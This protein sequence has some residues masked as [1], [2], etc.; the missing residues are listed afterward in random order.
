MTE[1]NRHRL[2]ALA[3]VIF[4][5]FIRLYHLDERVFHHD[6][7]V[8][9]F[10]TLR[11]LNE[12]IYQYDPTYHGPFL[13]HS[14]AAVF[15][16]LGISDFT[17]RLLPALFG[18]GALLLIFLLRKEL[19]PRGALF[20]AALLA[21]SPSMVY[22]SRFFRNDMF[23]VFFTLAM[24]VGA[25]RYRDNITSWRRI[26]YLLLASASLALAMTAKENAYIIFAMFSGYL[27]L[28]LLYHTAVVQKSGLMQQVVRRF[29]DNGKRNVGKLVLD[30]ILALVVFVGIFTLLYTSF[31]NNQESMFSVVESAFS[32]WSE[33]HRI[34]R[35]GGPWYFYLPILG[36]YESTILIFGVAGAV[37]YIR[38]K[39]PFLIFIA[40]WAAA[41]LLTYSY[42]QEKVPWLVVHIVLPFGILA[43]TYISEILPTLKFKPK[44]V[45]ALVV[46]IL[47]LSVSF[48]AYQSMSVNFYKSTDP[49]ELLVYTQASPDIFEVMDKI[50]ELDG[51]RN[52]VEI[53][54]ADPENLYWPLPWYLR[55]YKHRS[56]S[57]TVPL[58]SSAD[59]VIVPKSRS[60]D[61]AY[62][63]G[64]RY[65]SMQFDLRP[66]REFIMLYKP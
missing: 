9:G 43:G 32:H 42:L 66:G 60:E 17:A 13:F 22:Y 25:V 33:M 10:F 40:Y 37:H 27:G 47:V 15:S 46:G 7:S 51:G 49:D 36:M 38:E 35:I 54:V 52:R 31:F 5:L 48:S 19:T 62:S 28:L 53:L 6:E 26:P 34:E 61:L 56:Y 58:H 50:E 64:E 55:D 24:V 39:N 65:E 12:G 63:L 45:E 30:T 57:G 23:I 1:K 41:S 18:A 14:T 20:S 16:L 11:L 29:I 4:A 21:F 3:I 8:H 2:W 44:H 59:V